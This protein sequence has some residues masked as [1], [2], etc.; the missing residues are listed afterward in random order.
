MAIRRLELARLLVQQAARNEERQNGVYKHAAYDAECRQDNPS[1]KHW[2][3]LTITA[4]RLK[5]TDCLYDAD[6]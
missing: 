6:G 5:Q 3:V 4:E 1:A 2:G